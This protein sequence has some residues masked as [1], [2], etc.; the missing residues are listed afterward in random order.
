MATKIGTAGRDILRGSATADL[1]SGLAGND[2]LYG[3]AGNDTL[4]GGTGRDN[5]L[6]G[7][8][9]DTLDGNDRSDSLS[10]Q[11]GNDTLF[12]G[13]GADL[14]LPG[15]GTDLVNGGGG[16]DLVSYGDL[17]GGVG[18]AVDLSTGHGGQAAEGDTYISIEGVI[19]SAFADE[20]RLTT[21]GVGFGGGGNDRISSTAGAEM[22]GGVGTD[23]LI[24]DAAMVFADV[25]WC[26]R[27]ATGDNFVFFDRGQD[28]LRLKGSD[29]GFGRTLD[30]AEF[31]NNPTG[32][33]ATGAG[34]QLI[35][36]QA[37]KILWFDV[38]GTGPEFVI[39]VAL[40]DFVAGPASL[41]PRDF[42]LV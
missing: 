30:A 33:G 36:D 20:I 3:Y 1:L 6:G 28:I 12:G 18:V 11:G 14:L 27:H 24:G 17:K 13:S 10:G 9:N 39:P 22:H 8:G 41:S 29:F 23:D 15:T 21:A 32:F 16:F 38:D 31:N 40:F 42:D 19:G 26:E 35:Y 4:K 7:A 5:L 37:N 34:R 25:F 2:D